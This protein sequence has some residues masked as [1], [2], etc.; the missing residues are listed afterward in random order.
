MEPTDLVRRLLA[1]DGW[2]VEG[3]ST[4]EPIFEAR[5]GDA[6]LQV[7]ITQASTG[8]WDLLRGA[9]ADAVLRVSTGEATTDRL[10]VVS[11]PKVSAAMVDRLAQY[12]ALYAPHVSWGVIDRAGRAAFR[13][14]IQHDGRPPRRAPDDAPSRPVNVWSNVGQ[15]ILKVLVLPALDLGHWWLDP[16]RL[17][18]AEFADTFGVSRSFAWR[19]LDR[20]R[21]EQYI[22]ADNHVLRMADLLQQWRRRYE[23]S[24]AQPMRWLLPGGD[25]LSRL[26]A[27]TRGSGRAALGRAGAGKRVWPDGALAGF[28]AARSHAVAIV[29][30]SV[31]ELYVRDVEIA[32]SLQLIPASPGERADVFVRVPSAP[33]AVFRAA[34]EPAEDGATTIDLVQ[35]WIDLVDEPGRGREQAEIIWREVFKLP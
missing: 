11:A 5:R 32:R 18:D 7:A 17:P 20:L 1:E 33:D 8:T 22:D 13:G 25:S 3:T 15:W 31:P 12:H 27:A 24:I 2:R 16:V 4:S 35:C 29:P 14:V 10:A 26:R 28:T 21:R 9:L 6:R 30:A 19:V 34:A 23:P